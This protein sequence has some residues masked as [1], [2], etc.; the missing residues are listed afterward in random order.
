MTEKMDKAERYLLFSLFCLILFLALAIVSS[1]PGYQ[2]IIYASI[3]SAVA[4]FLLFL[5]CLRAMGQRDLFDLLGG[6]TSRIRRRVDDQ[7]PSV[8]SAVLDQPQ[9]QRV[10]PT[11]PSGPEVAQKD[12]P[13]PPPPPPPPSMPIQDVV[14]TV[15]AANMECPKCGQIL[16]A[17]ASF[18]GRCGTQIR[19]A[20]VTPP[21][22]I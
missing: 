9:S 14:Q 16:H 20:D 17:R 22:P 21:T 11:P 7:K 18:C 13:P 3:T 12:I 8:P 5:A 10:L 19:K 4:G 1:L 15:E 6:L 2:I